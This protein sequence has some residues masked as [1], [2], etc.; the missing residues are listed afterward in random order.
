M[1]AWP[2]IGKEGSRIGSASPFP[3][4]REGAMTLGRIERTIQSLVTSSSRRRFL[5]G[6]WFALLIAGPLPTSRERASA[7]HRHRHKRNR[8]RDHAPTPSCTPNCTDRSCGNDGCGGSCGACNASQ[9][10]QG[11]ACCSPQPPAATCAGRCGTWLDNCGQPVTCATCASDL[12]CL[13]NGTCAISCESAPCPGACGGCNDRNPE[14]LRICDVFGGCSTQE[15][16]STLECPPGMACLECGF[17]TF[18]C[19]TVCE[20]P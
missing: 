10:C 2:V 6:A 7:R 4:V 9:I 3:L 19:A 16:T 11:G 15:C 5:G 18:R 17:P 12:I 14:D 13:S 1:L 8:R 20:V